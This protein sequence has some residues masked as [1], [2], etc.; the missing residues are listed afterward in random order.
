MPQPPN[1]DFITLVDF[2]LFPFLSGDALNSAFQELTPDVT[3]FGDNS[4]GAAIVL[5]TIDSAVGVPIVPDPTANSNTNDRWRR[6]IWNRIPNAADTATR[7]ILYAWNNAIASDGTYLK[8]LPATTDL[9]SLQNQIT[10]AQS[11]ANTALNAANTANTNSSN[12]LTQASAA[13]NVATNAANSVAQAESDASAAAVAATTANNTA[14]TA[15]ATSNGASA[16]AANALSIAQSSRTI[17]NLMPGA[18]GQRIRV[19]YSNAPA[20]EYFNVRDTVTILTEQY[21]TG[22][23]GITGSVVGTQRPFNT[24]KSDTGGQVALTGGGAQLVAGVYRYKISCKVNKNSVSGVNSTGIRLFETTGATIID[25]LSDL[26]N[27]TSNTTLSMEGII[28]VTATQIYQIIMLG[29]SGGAAV[30]G[31]LAAN[32]S[33]INEIYTIATFERIG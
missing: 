16:V 4:Q 1:Q 8:W 7:S 5:T 22:V 20:L 10:T 24:I 13:V 14:N 28:S 25:T 26:T 18:T 29:G 3:S 15:I 12:A 21:G 9:T 30:A 32:V 27:T 2:T 6:Y 17:A 33:G 19:N 23:A 11:N 31:G